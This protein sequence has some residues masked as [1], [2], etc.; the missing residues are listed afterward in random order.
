MY[1]VLGSQITIYGSYMGTNKLGPSSQFHN[2]NS[3][4]VLHKL[5]KVRP[6]VVLT[7]SSSNSR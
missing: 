7:Y 1:A 6:I 5:I 2:Y 4:P 3:I